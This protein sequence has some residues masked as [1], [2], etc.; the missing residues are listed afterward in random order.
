[1][2]AD[3]AEAFY[4]V[5]YHIEDPREIENIERRAHPILDLARRFRL[6][7]SGGQYGIQNE[8][9]YLFIGARLAALGAEDNPEMTIPRDELL[10]IIADVDDKLAKA[11]ITD[12]PQLYCVYKFDY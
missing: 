10:R 4:G 3:A 6:R 5:R 11:G 2:S 9:F 1:M 8:R 7:T 12:E